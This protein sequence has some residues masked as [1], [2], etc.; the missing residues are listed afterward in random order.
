MHVWVDTLIMLLLI[1]KDSILHCIVFSQNYIFSPWLSSFYINS[2]PAPRWRCKVSSQGVLTALN[3][4]WPP[5]LMLDMAAISTAGHLS[6]Y[7]TCNLEERWNLFGITTLDRSPLQ[8]KSWNAMCRCAHFCPCCLYFQ[9]M[10]GALKLS[11]IEN[12][13]NKKVKPTRYDYSI[14]WGTFLSAKWLFQAYFCFNF[15]CTNI[16]ILWCTWMYFCQTTQKHPTLQTDRALW[17]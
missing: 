9:I 13:V 3:E 2:L 4:V 1:V 8:S 7:S 15:H 16:I 14:Y 17:H 11:S 5:A 12:T 10:C 6:K